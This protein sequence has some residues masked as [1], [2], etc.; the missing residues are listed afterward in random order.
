MKDCPESSAAKKVRDVLELHT[1]D[2]RSDFRFSVELDDFDSDDDEDVFEVSVY[3]ERTRQR[4]GF[5]AAVQKSDP[6]KVLME[7][8][9]R[10]WEE[11]TAVTFWS[12]LY[13]DLAWEKS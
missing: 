4:H 9:D 7:T 13:L 12:W 5:R 8:T 3:H 2:W 6:S 10:C 1:N 11:M